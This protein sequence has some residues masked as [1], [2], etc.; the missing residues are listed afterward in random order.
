MVLARGNALYKNKMP[1]FKKVACG[2]FGYYMLRV[3]PKAAVGAL[4]V[5]H[6][7]P[8]IRFEDALY[9]IHQN[10]FMFNAKKQVRADDKIKMGVGEI[11]AMQALGVAVH[12]LDVLQAFGKREVFNPRQKLVMHVHRPDHPSRR[13]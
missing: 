3:G 6:Q 9:L 12:H 7:H 10:F 8:G 2:G 13:S 4:P 11:G 1:G 5:D